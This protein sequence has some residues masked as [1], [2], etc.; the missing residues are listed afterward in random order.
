MNISEATER[1]EALFPIVDTTTIYGPDGKHL[2]CFC[3][4]NKFTP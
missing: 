3:G 1:F 2:H 4:A